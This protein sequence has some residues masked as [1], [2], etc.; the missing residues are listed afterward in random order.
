MVSLQCP[1]DLCVF[2]RCQAWMLAGAVGK[3]Q[4]TSALPRSVRYMPGSPPLM[5]DPWP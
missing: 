2:R 5:H 3:R 1:E 4:E